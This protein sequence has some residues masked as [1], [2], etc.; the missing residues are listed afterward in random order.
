M[1]TGAAGGRAVACTICLCCVPTGMGVCQAEGRVESRGVPMGPFEGRV[2][3]TFARNLERLVA[4][5]SAALLSTQA[6]FWADQGTLL[7]LWRHG[8]PVMRYDTD[9]DFGVAA[10]DF[11]LALQ[12]LL[13]KPE[14]AVKDWRS[15][16][17]VNHFEVSLKSAPRVRADIYSF[18]FDKAGG[19]WRSLASFLQPAP[20][21]ALLPL[22]WAS[23]GQLHIPV[24]QDPVTWLCATEHVVYQPQG[25]LV[26]DMV[27]DWRTRRYVPRGH[28]PFK[29]FPML[30]VVLWL[31]SD[32]LVASTV[33]ALHEQDYPLARTEVVVVGGVASSLFIS[34]ASSVL[35][36]PLWGELDEAR[37]SG[38]AVCLWDAQ[39]SFTPHRL[40]AQIS[41]IFAEDS[42]VTAL[43]SVTGPAPSTFCWRRGHQTLRALLLDVGDGAAWSGGVG[44]RRLEPLGPE[45]MPVVPV[46]LDILSAGQ[47]VN[48]KWSK[49]SA[50]ADEL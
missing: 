28:E 34:E 7:A 42:D 14:L 2:Q 5:I 8:S 4:S 12:A 47:M 46:P 32:E 18:S 40:S 41:P 29:D 39:A 37:L 27:F 22:R 15:D 49:S 33:A 36:E 44:R 10:E 38:V 6:C 43:L 25:I 16:H 13:G 23:W 26:P 17:N 1:P 45:R 20:H 48:S 24:P 3:R 31:P 50:T 35:H 30:S 11:D 9:A 19:V 21:T